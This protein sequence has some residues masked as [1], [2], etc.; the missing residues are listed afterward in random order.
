M[1]TTNFALKWFF[2][3]VKVLVFDG[4]R[5]NSEGFLADFAFVFGRTFMGFNVHFDVVFGS[6]AVLTEVTRV[7]IVRIVY[8]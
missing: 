3:S 8:D 1:F 6:V 4:M 7:L 5:T 2:S